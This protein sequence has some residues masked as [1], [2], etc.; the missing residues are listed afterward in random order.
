MATPPRTLAALAPLLLLAACSSSSGANADREAPTPAPAPVLDRA[1]S[2]PGWQTVPTTWNERWWLAAS[3]TKNGVGRGTTFD[4]GPFKAGDAS[5]GSIRAVRGIEG[6][7][8]VQPVLPAGG[9]LVALVTTDPIRGA[10][11]NSARPA[12]TTVHVINLANGRHVW[13]ATLPSPSKRP[14]RLAVRD[15]AVHHTRAGVT[16]CWDLHTGAPLSVEQCQE[17]PEEQFLDAQGQ[18]VAP[19]ADQDEVARSADVVLLTGSDKDGAAVLRAHSLPD[20]RL[21]WTDTLDPDPLRP[22]QWRRDERYVL[23]TEGRLLRAHYEYADDP[24]T[25]VAVLSE[26]DPRTGEIGDEVGRVEGGLMLALVGDVAVLAVDQNAGLRSQ[27]AGF[28]VPGA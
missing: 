21:L 9:S 23:S 17:V 1:W 26:V 10:L 5:D 2:A 20:G 7:T 28:V 12:C 8:C 6:F 11:I 13:R 15:G 4:P 18:P 19:L 14:D 24:A 25:S 3:S 22:E 16:S 27:I